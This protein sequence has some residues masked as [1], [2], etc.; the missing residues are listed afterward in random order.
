MVVGFVSQDKN[1]KKLCES[2][3]LSNKDQERKKY[4]Y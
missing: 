1:K 3:E 4:I 2:F